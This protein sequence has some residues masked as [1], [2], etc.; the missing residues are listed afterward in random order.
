MGSV[1]LAATRPM[2]AH[3]DRDDNTSPEPA[4]GLGVKSTYWCDI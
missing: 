3:P 2:P 1:S 4:E